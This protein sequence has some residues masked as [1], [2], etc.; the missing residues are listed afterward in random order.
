VARRGFCSALLF[1]LSFSLLIREIRL[2]LGYLGNLLFIVD[3]AVVIGVL[4]IFV[5]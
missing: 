1:L 5:L 3:S 4:D 2:G